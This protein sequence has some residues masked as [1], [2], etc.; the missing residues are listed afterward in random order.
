[1]PDSLEIV[2]DSVVQERK[3]DVS[4]VSS[5]WGLEKEGM[6]ISSYVSLFFFFFFLYFLYILFFSLLP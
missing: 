6:S 3:R 2:R 5:P 4:S 1:M